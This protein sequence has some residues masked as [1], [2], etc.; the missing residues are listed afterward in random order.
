MAF[1]AIA[2]AGRTRTPVWNRA[3]T[4]LVGLYFADKRAAVDGGFQSLL[5]DMNIG[6]RLGHPIDREQQLA[7][8]LWYYYGGRYG[9]YLGSVTR[10]PA[11]EDFLP[12]MLE[13]SPAAY[14]SYSNLAE[15]YAD[16]GDIPGAIADYEHALELGPNNVDA[17]DR[18]A[19]ML[20]RANSF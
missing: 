17:R 1:A 10:Q 3:Y 16:A 15:Y 9:E 12:A 7:G 11:A 13:R 19:V 8:D 4:G 2:V 20:W 18:Y 5:G 14:A 6:S